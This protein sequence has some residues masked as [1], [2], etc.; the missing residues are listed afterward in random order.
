MPDFYKMY[1]KSQFVVMEGE[2]GSGKTTQLS[3]DLVK[4][5]NSS[6]I[7]SIDC[8]ADYIGSS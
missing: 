3:L 6:G 4:E 5:L 7:I 1:N 8:E 2:T